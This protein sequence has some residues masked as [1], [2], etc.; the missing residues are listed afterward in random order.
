VREAG[1]GAE[2]LALLT[3][4]SPVDVIVADLRMPRMDGRQLAAE[5]RK[6]SLAVPILFISGY[7]A[8]MGQGDLPGPVLPKPFMPDQLVASVRQLLH[9]TQ[10]RSA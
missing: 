7:D 4:G 8:H 6:L 5:V 10:P 1:D 3:Q 9:G 2:A